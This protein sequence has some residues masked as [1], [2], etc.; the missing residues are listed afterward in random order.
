[1]HGFIVHK[2]SWQY[3]KF[4][5]LK[6]RHWA[7]VADVYES[8]TSSRSTNRHYI[9]KTQTLHRICSP[10][11]YKIFPHRINPQDIKIYILW[12]NPVDWFLS[13]GMHPV[14]NMDNV[15]HR[16]Y[17]SCG[18][19]MSC[20]QHFMSCGQHNTCCSP[21]DIRWHPQDT[22]TGYVLCLS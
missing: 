3:M 2:L 19:H 18:V 8:Q 14:G 17:T 1:M 5:K 11:G 20:G 7:I 12:I 9:G 21:Q 6:R 22:S 16:I 15:V 13:C 10:T 4:F